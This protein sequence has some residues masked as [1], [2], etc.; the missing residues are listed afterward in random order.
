[1]ALTFYEKYSPRR[2]IRLQQF[3]STFLNGFTGSR[4]EIYYDGSSDTLRVMDGVEIGGYPLARSDLA[5]VSTAILSEKTKATG[6]VNTGSSF[7]L[8][9]FDGM[10]YYNSIQ[11]KL[12][13]YLDDGSS[14]QAWAEISTGGGGGN[15]F[16][17]ISV[18]GQTNVVADSATDT[19][20]LTAGS[21]IAITTNSG[22]DTVTIASSIN[23]FSTISVAGQSNVVAD[24]ASDT[25][26]LVAGSGIV[27]TTNAGSDTITIETSGG[28]GGGA[29]ALDDLTDVQLSTPLNN[30]VLKYNGSYWTNA[31]DATAGG[32]SASNSFETIVVAGQSSV[33]ADSSTDQLTLIAGSGLSITTNAVTDAVTFSNT[34]VRSITVAGTG[35]AID[36]STGD[37]TIT[38]S[39][40]GGGGLSYSISSETG[41]GGANLRL[42]D[43]AAG[44]DDVLFAGSGSVSVTRTDA[45]TITITGSTPTINLDDL[46]DVV[47]TSPSNNQ[48]LKYN[49]SQWVNGTD[50][51]SGGGGASNSFETIVVAGQSSVVAD[52]STDSLTLVAG[53]GITI[54]TNATTDAITIT[55]SQ[56]VFSGIAVAGQATVAADAAPDQVTF[57]AGSGMAITTDAVN[58]SV[59]FSSTVQPYSFSVAGDDS[60]LRTIDNGESVKFIGAGLVTTATSTEGAVTITGATPNFSA[61]GQVSTAGVTVDEIYIQAATRYDVTNNGAVGYLFDQVG[62]SLTDNPTIRLR[63]GITVAFNLNVAGHPFLIQFGGANYNTGLIHVDTSGN[64][65]TGS[66]AQ[67]QTSGTLYWKIP[68]NINLAFTYRCS[69]HAGMTGAIRVY[70][71]EGS[72]DLAIAPTGS[73][74]ATAYNMTATINNITSI[75][76]GSAVS[77]P[78]SPLPGQR[79]TVMNNAA[80]AVSV[81]CSGGS[82]NSLATN[83]AYSLPAGGRLDFISTTTTQWYSLNPFY[84]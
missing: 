54:T 83:T 70:R 82:I 69:I 34:G 58:D 7:P 21:G 14:Y 25:L 41:T 3:D 36:S 48:V 60:T 51:T 44:T 12:Y 49:G 43:S 17:T 26:T 27:L 50:A 16:T 45:N 77:L 40:G 59:T 65:L 74:L 15:S 33:I 9:P 11:E 56:N 5:N 22:T 1:M 73:V 72:V 47:I 68:A 35:I 75:A 28:G 2:L 32:G 78:T 10:L 62:A 42:T 20:T 55:N 4:G 81:F 79:V 76:S 57:I 18:A 24:S 8:A 29:S 61:L 13:I 19:L 64:V 23:S 53:T 31:T 39:A 67:G 84:T 80:G 66:S 46:A 37:V 63:A 30:Q 52:S 6:V 38:G 71:E